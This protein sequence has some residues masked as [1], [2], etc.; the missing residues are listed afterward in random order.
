[1]L[2]YFLFQGRQNLVCGDE[3]HTAPHV[4]E[5]VSPHQ[6]VKTWESFSVH[7]NLNIR[8]T[9]SYYLKI[10]KTLQLH[11]YWEKILSK[12]QESPSH[13]YHSASIKYYKQTLLKNKALL[14]KI[15]NHCYNIFLSSYF[16]I[17]LHTLAPR[18]VASESL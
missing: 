10:W 16:Y 8:Y 11:M 18:H 9:G 13:T 6:Y 5:L 17:L 15:I 3:G 7:P 12:Y 4:A 2:I 14:L 1:M